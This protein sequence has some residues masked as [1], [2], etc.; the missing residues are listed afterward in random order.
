MRRTS[1]LRVVTTPG[2]SSPVPGGWGAMAGAKAAIASLRGRGGPPVVTG[3]QHAHTV[4][5]GAHARLGV[6]HPAHGGDGAEQLA[7]RGE[8]GERGEALA[9]RPDQLRLTRPARERVLGTNPQ[10]LDRL[11]VVVD[12]P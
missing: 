2:A 5:V 4:A 1:G 3:K 8:G 12:G 6:G 9:C 7:R 11:A 10:S